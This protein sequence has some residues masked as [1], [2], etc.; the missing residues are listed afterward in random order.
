MKFIK[1]K[2]FSFL[3]FFLLFI[4]LTYSLF[5][6]IQAYFLV[7]N[8]NFKIPT[9]IQS[10]EIQNNYKYLNQNLKNME[11]GKDYQKAEVII[12]FDNSKIDLDQFSLLSQPLKKMF[13]SKINNFKLISNFKKMNTA[14][15]KIKNE[16]LKSV[17]TQLQN[18]SL[19]EYAEPNYFF[20]FVEEKQNTTQITA[21]PESLINSDFINSQNQIT[22]MENITNNEW[23]NIDSWWIEKIQLKPSWEMEQKKETQEVIVAILDQ[24]VDYRHPDLKNNMWSSQKCFNQ[25]NQTISC[26]FHGWNFFQNT[27]NT[28]PNFELE[29]SNHGTA[30]AGVIASSFNLEANIAGFSSKNKIKIMTLAVGGEQANLQA[31]INSI[32]FAQNNGAKIINASWGSQHP[33]ITLKNAIENFDGLFVTAAMNNGENN[34][35]K[36]IYPCNFQLKNLICV[37]AINK[38]NQLAD[39]SNYST[40]FVHLVAPGESILSTANNNTYT[41]IDGT[42]IA[43]PQV[44]GLIALI[45]SYNSL[46]SSQE[47]KNIVFD[48]GSEIENL[49]NKTV[50]GKVINVFQALK[51]ADRLNQRYN[52]KANQIYLYL[53]DV[54]P[55]TIVNLTI[56]DQ[57]YKLNQN[58]TQMQGNFQKQSGA[59]FVINL[60]NKIAVN[61]F[62]QINKKTKFRKTIP[63]NYFTLFSN[64]YDNK[65]FQTL[66]SNNRNQTF[67]LEILFSQPLLAQVFVPLENNQSLK[68]N[69]ERE[70]TDEKKFSPLLTNLSTKQ[71][72]FNFSQL[73]NKT[74]LTDT[75]KLFLNNSFIIETNHGFWPNSK[76]VLN[77]NQK[78]IYQG[79][80]NNGL[81]KDDN[82][83]FSQSS[84]LININPTEIIPFSF[85]DDAQQKKPIPTD[86][87]MIYTKKAPFVNS[88]EPIIKNFEFY[89]NQILIHGYLINGA[90]IKIYLPS[91]DLQTYNHANLTKENIINVPVL[92][93]TQNTPGH[94]IKN[95]KFTNFVL[96]PKFD[97]QIKSYEFEGN[98]DPNN[99]TFDDFQAEALNA[100]DEIKL[101]IG[102]EGFSLTVGSNDVFDTYN[103]KSKFLMWHN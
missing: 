8:N 42:S 64:F 31:G 9:K 18:N 99:L 78:E 43:T 21:N 37:G 79:I 97:P 101:I 69:K 4:S 77:I 2:Y 71:N 84:H 81:A 48:S 80:F 96:T 11:P 28:L 85:I 56:N 5:T 62:Q 82:G 38:K 7:I 25:E 26:P 46:L 27:N 92:E 23:E 16:D 44:S 74:L 67:N 51:N 20:N 87:K 30:V 88:Q 95:L 35:V 93:P 91:V 47:I 100:D 33:N 98:Q 102:N 1:K 24:G 55:D 70:L 40:Q 86:F 22:N 75:E 17:I 63:N 52:I 39:F 72:T 59:T 50:T 32:Y 34:D 94:F 57:T 103:F 13:F 90:E 53:D 58:Q 68:Q 6:I 83:I 76:V 19:V 89:L 29:F 60:E 41:T 73:Q 54:N 14:I 36:P 61:T 66:I 65:S 49:K 12:K 10:T 45:S 3:G 15:F